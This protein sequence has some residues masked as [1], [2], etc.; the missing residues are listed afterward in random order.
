MV[1]VETTGTQVGRIL[2]YAR[3]ASPGVSIGKL[4]RRYEKRYFN[5]N[6]RLRPRR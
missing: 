4:V 2:P 5:N 1:G 6:S 3:Q